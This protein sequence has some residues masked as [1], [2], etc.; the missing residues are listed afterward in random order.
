MKL[1]RIAGL[2]R[3]KFLYLLAAGVVVLSGV[4]LAFALFG[5]KGGDDEYFTETLKRGPMRTVVDATGTVQAVVTVQVGSQVSGQIE[6]LYADYNSVVK[7]GQLLAKIDPRNFEAT[8]EDSKANLAAAEAHV[9]SLKAALNTQQANLEGA[10]ASLVA[11]QV[12]RDNDKMILQRYID[13]D[14]SGLV[15]Q[16]DY[17]TV[18]ATADSSQAKYQ[19]AVAAVQQQQAQ[20]NAAKAELE[21]AEAQV[22][23]A[24]ADLNRA[25]INLAYTNI[26]SP[27]DGVVVS[28]NVDV[29]Q[30]VAA[31]LQAP[32]LFLIANDLTKMQVNASV[33]EADIGHLSTDTDVQFTVDAYPNKRFSGRIAEIRL[34][35]QTIQNV[36]TYSVII[37]VD[38]PDYELRPGM[39]ANLTFAV[40]SRAE[41]L[42]L[43]NAAL[44]YLPSGVTQEQ[45][46]AMLGSLP[47]TV[48]E[49]GQEQ[50]GVRPQGISGGK[51]NAPA[52]KRKGNAPVAA[53]MPEAPGQMWNPEDK[54]QFAAPQR[55]SVRP[56]V[57]WVLNDSD[58]P[59]PERVLLGITDGTYTE[60]VSSNLK[61]GDR[62]II[63]DAL[64]GTG[65]PATGNGMRF[66]LG[67]GPPRPAKKG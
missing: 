20:I 12:A 48:K 2:W 59:V 35:P 31:S 64:H 24:K 19:Q 21:Q 33:D 65:S 6:A 51:T 43:P 52:H 32:L 16:N 38:N 4:S 58:K 30:T 56:A 66:P 53:D 39:T 42:K 46:A 5:R 47:P 3:G 13:L 62:V 17:D 18:K 49:D 25:E 61:E 9:Q 36:V 37:N 27:V 8:V 45:V 10:K 22:L 28:R 34:N 14:R 67:F 44:R 54:I 29:G 7:R 26:F 63:A 60:V 57:I 40:A 55:Q 15:A 50:T 23:Q 1:K 41:A 11:A